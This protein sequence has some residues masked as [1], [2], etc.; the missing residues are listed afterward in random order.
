MKNQVRRARQHLIPELAVAEGIPLCTLP[1]P[2]SQAEP[3]PEQFRDVVSALAPYLTSGVTLNPTIFSAV[4]SAAASTIGASLEALAPAQYLGGVRITTDNVLL[5]WNIDHVGTPYVWTEDFPLSN[6]LQGANLHRCAPFSEIARGRVT[7]AGYDGHMLLPVLAQQADDL[8]SENVTFHPREVTRFTQGTPAVGLHHFDSSFRY[9]GCI[10]PA[11]DEEIDELFTVLIRPDCFLR[12]TISL[13][14]VL[15]MTGVPGDDLDRA[16]IA[17]NQ[18]VRN[19][20]PVAPTPGVATNVQATRRPR[21]S[22]TGRL[23]DDFDVPPA[24]V[25]PSRASLR[26]FSRRSASNSVPPVPASAPAE[27]DLS[28]I[29]AMPAEPESI[30]FVWPTT[31]PPSASTTYHDVPIPAPRPPATPSF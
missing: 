26:A 16:E 29:A 4:L 3:P 17:Y 1:R 28:T 18:L 23:I 10:R 19:E 9:T 24:P 11:T 2:P 12:S 15:A 30:P 31:L 22:A 5:S 14:D 8:T 7:I 13:R 21:R 27:V 20:A 6:L 25:P